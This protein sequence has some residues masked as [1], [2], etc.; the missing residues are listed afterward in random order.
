VRHRWEPPPGASIDPRRQLWM[1]A[2]R[3]PA[4]ARDW[5]GRSAPARGLNRCTAKAAH[6]QR[7]PPRASR[8]CG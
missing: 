6:G 7:P 8:G 1:R 2:L 3:L 5:L 4:L